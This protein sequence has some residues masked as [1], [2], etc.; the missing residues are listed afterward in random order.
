MD[1]KIL[2]KPVASCLTIFAILIMVHGFEAIVLRMDETVIG[3]NFINKVF[4]I[5]LLCIVLNLINWKWSDIGF[6]RNG[7]TKSICLGFA[8][9]IISFI[10][11][12]SIEIFILRSQGKV[13]DFGVFTTGFSLTGEAEVH[14]GIGFILMCVFFNI[15]NVLMEEGTFRGLFNKLVAT[16]HSIKFAL[17]FQAVLFGIWHIVTPLHNLIDGDINLVAFVGLGVGYIILAGL[18]GIKWGL[19]YQMTGSLYAGMADHFF[20]NCI[21]TNLLHV[22]TESGI[23]EMMII[24][25]MVAQLLSFVIVLTGWKR[26]KRDAIKLPY[27]N[28]EE[29]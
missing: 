22:V 1:E 9:A 7:F 21:A 20:N 18:M 27:P 16:N 11:S 13:T 5:V 4:G 29:N 3:E 19:M 2:K 12:Y 10:V 6:A 17:V 15:I 8:L 26:L 24:R 14:R 28:E 25:V 23:D